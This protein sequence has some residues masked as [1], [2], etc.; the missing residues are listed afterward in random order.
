MKGI[1]KQ[2]SK[3]LDGIAPHKYNPASMGEL[4]QNEQQGASQ[5]CF[6]SHVPNLLEVL[7]SKRNL[8]EENI[9][10]LVTLDKKVFFDESAAA[11]Q[12]CNLRKAVLGVNNVISYSVKQEEPFVHTSH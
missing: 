12:Y 3:P 1:G 10:D 4:P 9:A 7:L 5:H 8:F 11:D 2:I 6:Q